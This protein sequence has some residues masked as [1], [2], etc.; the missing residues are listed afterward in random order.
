M[1]TLQKQQSSNLNHR[2]NTT[3]TPA[4]S[5]LP[6]HCCEF[7]CLIEWYLR[8]VFHAVACIHFCFLCANSR[9]AYLGCGLLSTTQYLKLIFF[10]PVP[11]HA[12]IHFVVPPSGLWPKCIRLLRLGLP[13]GAVMLPRWC[14]WWWYVWA[15]STRRGLKPKFYKL[16]RPWS[17]WGSS[18]AKEN[19]YG[20]TRNRTLNFMVSSQKLRP[21]SHKAGKLIIYTFVFTVREYIFSMQ[22]HVPYGLRGLLSWL[23]SKCNRLLRFGRPWGA[24]TFS[25]W[26]GWWY[27]NMK[28]QEGP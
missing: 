1:S 14:E 21:P 25:R 4:V 17:L 5:S 12:L 3:F 20:R 13:W 10:P 16:P 8:N 6:A 7:V 19:S 26:G 24:V 27:M 9:A 22:P 2:I 23:R 18:S 28:Y 11:P 15:W